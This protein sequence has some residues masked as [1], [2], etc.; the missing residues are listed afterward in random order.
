MESSQGG[1][2]TNPSTPI[3]AYIVWGKSSYYPEI[4]ARLDFI[5]RIQIHLK[6]REDGPDLAEL[7]AGAASG[8]R[9]NAPGTHVCVYNADA[10]EEI[11][12]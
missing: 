11:S 10:L 9:G 3:K 4:L 2:Y 8:L 5:P 12:C 7:T 1:V 6:C